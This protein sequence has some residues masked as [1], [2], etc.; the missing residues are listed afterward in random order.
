MTKSLKN[1]KNE[2]CTSRT[3]NMAKKLKITEN[4]NDSLDD[5]QNDEISENVEK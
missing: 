1:V 2:K 5:L 3:W 4:E